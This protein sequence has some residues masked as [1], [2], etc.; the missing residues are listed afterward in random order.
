MMTIG[1]GGSREVKGGA[2][3]TRRECWENFFL[4]FLFYVT[5]YLSIVLSPM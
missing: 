3:K 2:G 5:I 4:R 1:Q